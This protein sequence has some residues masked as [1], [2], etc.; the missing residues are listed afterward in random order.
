D[1]GDWSFHRDRAVRQLGPA[2]VP[3]LDELL[4]RDLTQ[5]PCGVRAELSIVAGV[6]VVA[7]ELESVL[8]HPHGMRPVLGVLLLRGSV[9][10]V[11]VDR[12]L[13][14]DHYVVALAYVL[15]RQVA[16]EAAMLAHGSIPTCSLH[17]L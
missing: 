7:G 1:G 17:I 8:A 16:H 12:E 14:H 9:H 3:C 6:R 5:T 15:S 11:A 4:A 13:L 10:R 2:V